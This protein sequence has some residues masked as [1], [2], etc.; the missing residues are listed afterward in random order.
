L[1]KPFSRVDLTTTVRR[2]IEAARAA[3]TS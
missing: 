2:I 1:R 3:A